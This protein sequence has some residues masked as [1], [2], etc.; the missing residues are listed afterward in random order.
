MKQT[1]ILLSGSVLLG[2]S[3]CASADKAII[4]MSKQ[5]LVEDTYTI[6]W[7]GSSKAYRFVDQSW[8][9]AENYDYQFNVIQKRYKEQWKSVKT[10]QRIH[11]E[12]D[13]KA[14]ERN[15]TMYFDLTFLFKDSQYT[16]VLNS[17][18]GTGTGTS[19]LE[20]RSQS[21]EFKVEGISSLAP[22]DHIRITQT[23]K[24]EEGILEETVLL[25]K[26][27]GNTETPFMKNEEKAFF[28]T[29]GHLTSAPSTSKQ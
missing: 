9:R 21:I 20:Y 1:L 15:Q 19:D 16:S 28:Y 24:Y 17:S 25:F 12:Y 23:Y 10:L 2:F 26:K 29:K 8:Q 22:Y 3:G 4:P 18:L 7:N 13:G 6:I 5:L 14:G 27:K 11:P